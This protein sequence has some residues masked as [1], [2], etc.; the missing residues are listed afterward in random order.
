[1][2]NFFTQTNVRRSLSV[3]LFIGTSFFS[4]GQLSG[5]YT[6]P[7][8]Y[9]SINAFITDLN[10]VGVGP[11]G[12]T[13][14]VPAGYTETAPAGGFVIT[15]TGNATDQITI[16]GAGLPQPV[17]TAS[18]A[19]TVGALNDGIFKL[20]GSDYVTIAN[21]ELRENA[22]N[23]TTASATNNMTEW[24]VA[25]L[26]AS[27]TDGAKNNTIIGNT[28]SLNRT[29]TNSFGIYSNVRHNATAVTTAADI[30]APSG[31]NS[32]NLVYG[33]VISNVN[34][35][36]A[37]IGS[38]VP[39]NMDNG[40]DIGGSSVTSGNTITNWGGAGAASGYISNS[41]ISYCIFMNHQIGSNISYN[42]LTSATV[43]GTSVTFRGIVQDFT[44]AA[45]TGT[46][47]NNITNNQITMSSG[48]T[49][50]T[51]QHIF[52]SIFAATSGATLNINSNLLLNSSMSG[53]ASSSTM[54]GIIN[55]GAYGTVNINNNVLRG[56]TSTATTGGMTGISNT[57]AVVN[58]INM[59]NNALG[60]ASGNAITH[61]VAT[62]GAYTGISNTGGASTCALSIT[63][64]NFQGFVQSVNGTN[65]HTYITNSATT[66]SQ[67]IN[68]NT[69]TNLVAST[70][71]N[72][73]FI[74]NSVA[75]AATGIQNVNSN[76]ISGTFSKPGAGGTITL[77][78]TNASSAAG[79]IVSNSNNN[80]SNIT[81]TGAATIAGWVN[82]DGGSPQKTIANNT[83][84]N[85]TG[86]TSAITVIQQ[87][88]G[89]NGSNITN[90]TI[91]NISGQGA[92]TAINF[93]ASNSGAAQVISGNT[94]S[95]I[96]S[97]G[98]GGAVLGITTGSS[99]VTSLSI[100]GNNVNTLSS[101]AAS[102]VT[103]LA[104]SGGPQVNTFKNKF[105]AL[106]T[107]NAGGTVIGVL[108]S[109]GTATNTHNNLISEL[110]A[111]NASGND[112]IRGI[113]LTATTATTN[114]LVAYNTIYLNATSVGANFGTTGIFHNGSA[115][116]TT[117]RLDLRNNVIINESTPNGTGSTVAF[118]RFT[119][120]STNLA[121]TSN[122]NM[123]YAGTPAANR[124][125]YTD[126]TTP[127]QTLL[128]YQ[129]SVLPV[130][131]DANSM[132]G[133]AAFT[134]LGYGSAGNF[135]ISLT[136]SSND[137]LRPV[138]GITTQVESGASNITVPSITDDYTSAARQGNA[139]YTGT[140]TNPDMGAYEFEG[141]SP[142]PVIT[143]NSVTPPSTTQCTA[144]ARLISV[145]ITTTAG[146]ITSANIGYTMNGVAQANIPMTNTSGNIWEGT[147]PA[148]TPGNAVIAWGVSATNSLG[149]NGSYTGTSY[150]DEPLFGATATATA[151]ATTVCAN[152]PSTLTAS[153]S[154]VGSSVSGS[155]TG[156]S[157]AS[158]IS[159][160]YH[161]YGGVK[162]QYIFR[163]SELTA[164]G[165]TAGNFS[166]LSLNVTAVGTATR[167]NFT[168]DMGHTAQN[169]AVTNTAITAGL[170]Q[171]YSNAAQPVVLGAN[172][173]NF[174]TPF[175]WDGVSNIVIS[176]NWSNVNTGGTSAT[177]T[178]DP[179]LSFV[180]SLA[181]FADNAT[182][183]CLYT[184]VS[185]G[186]ACMGTNSNSTSSTRP[187]MTFTGQ[188]AP[189]ITSVQ[190]MDGA[191]PVGTG[192]PV[193]VNPSVT[194]TYTANITAAGCVYSPAPTVTVNVNPLPSTPTAA[195]S[196]QCGTQV[197]TASVTS[198]S[199]LPTPTFNW[200]DAPTAGT[201]LQNSTSTTYTS[202]VA[203]TTTFYVSELNTATGC[204]SARVAVTVT[205]AAADGIAAST[206]ATTIC[207]GSSF[208][209]S[210]VNTNPTPNQNYT[211]TWSS[212]ANSGANPSVNG[213]NVT[214]TP[215]EPGTYTYDVT[216][217]DG[218]CNAF[219]QVTVTVDPFAAT[220]AP[221]N[222]S[223]NG[224]ADGSFTLVS[225]SCGTIPYTYS[226]DG[227][228]F[229]AIPT[230][231]PAGTY[232]IIVMDDNGYVTPD[233]VITI[234][235]PSTTITNPSVTN[236]TVCQNDPSATVT[237]SAFTSVP[238]PGTL[239]ASFGTNLV[240]DGQ[241][242]AVYNVTVPALPANAT[243]TGTT[244]LLQNVNAING[245]WRS[246][247][248]VALSGASTLGATQISTLGSGGLITPDPS[249]TIPNLPLA[250]GTVTLS[251]TETYNDGGATVDAT[252]GEVSIIIN[253][254]TPT[255]ATVSW[256]DA[257]TGG[258][259]LG[260]GSPFETV[261][262]SVLPNTAT[263]GTYTVYAQGQNGAC[264]S[265]GRT[266][267]TI[268][269]K[270]KT[271]NTI[272]Q[273]ACNSYTLNSQTYTTS[274]TYTQTLVNAA[275]CD[276]IIT[277]NLT[278]NYSTTSTTNVTECDTYTWTNGIT[279]TTSGVYTQ[280]L[281][282]AAGCDSIATLNLTINYSNTGTDVI[283]ACE[284]YTW[285][286]GNTYTSS[287]N[288][289]TFL[290]TNAAGCDSLVTLNLTINYSNTGTD[291]ITACDSYTWIDGNTYTSNNNTATFLLTNAA[292][293]DSL[294]TLDLTI[295]SSNTGTD[296]VTACDSY[297]WIDGNTYTSSNNT[298]T[299]VLTNAAGCDS[300]VT[301]NLTI[302][303]S[304]AGTDVITA[305]DS[306][307]WIDGNTYTSS[308]NTATYVLTN[309]VG[310][311]SLVTLDLTIN[312]ST[313]GTDVINSCVPITWI[314][315]NTYASNNNTATF[316]LT[317]AAGCDSIV[318]LNLTI[319]PIPVATAT[320]NGD[321]SITAS[322]GNS[323]EWIDCA[324]GLTIAGESSQTYVATV[325]GSYQVVVFNASGCSDT[326]TCVVI[327]YIG[328]R[329]ISSEMIS[330]YPNPTS[331]NVTISMSAATA[332]V[333]ILDG[334]GKLIRS[335]QIE[336]GKPLDL[337]DLGMG[338]YLFRIT[339][340]TNTTIHRV[341][342]N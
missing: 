47:T 85:W 97:T 304:S 90:N 283:T 318:T 25:L 44:V 124:L 234:T 10:L 299:Y 167:N 128:G 242:P 72:I 113:S 58:T 146:T 81:V 244:L 143:L 332:S 9:P 205:V 266:A 329:E 308:N 218:L 33:N 303:Y 327:D 260:T 256:W 147:I 56:W 82:T 129:T 281:T 297:T 130:G 270:A 342:K 62:N 92:I 133:E 37:F 246:E 207:I 96:N 69:F 211:Y 75:L 321:A 192:N 313:T 20:I 101:T 116:A 60:N 339:T 135:F 217:V 34:L 102:A 77:Y 275:G 250:G 114:H 134:A 178:T 66:L 235:E 221:V 45:P 127:Q 181:I 323:Y 310:C 263:P 253:Y 194:T 204:E 334:N 177:V 166:S 202:N 71:G 251:L 156:T 314:D 222:A 64:N 138:A 197:P 262:T 14:S 322:A 4:F 94:I 54:V 53:A 326:S 216:G 293:C 292:G 132:T 337:S 26:Y 274:G 140:G 237:A 109:G 184:A 78:T 185:S 7:A 86:G 241:A 228:A 225:S 98:T 19:L 301:L 231:L 151:S 171:V 61:S 40:N 230:D 227:G 30:T 175:N 118:R 65:S 50:G 103:G 265:P 43:T 158:A 232:T 240:S 162:T 38:S 195:N 131:H 278:I 18:A 67:N 282:N 312:Y 239:T 155:G 41:G 142:A 280:T 198:T 193:T 74:S 338:V 247:I 80:F 169:A 107:S 267:A 210:V 316:V 106:S 200:Y 238:I 161:F 209:L 335:T 279:Y 95:G 176:F 271:Y 137:F 36:I 272:N 255:P 150:S 261:G 16:T 252:F 336:N 186:Q 296:V 302:K 70:T 273:T 305:C 257:P 157:S 93:G 42:T 121:S 149:L 229:G 188:K 73:T 28:I 288:T 306:Y 125:I 55:T 187:T 174:S 17:I 99:T 22:A 268:V 320:D 264:P 6:I 325:N 39:A 12:V 269:V 68:G 51:F 164:M 52:T 160:L 233:Q 330:I 258:T 213:A 309:A 83:F 87:N 201:L 214:I 108:I 57:G 223:C 220:I 196:A 46:F 163:A 245:S 31:S 277:L 120:N 276:S 212:V 21:L 298:A 219:A 284:S 154:N 126:G 110:T 203:S 259:Q 249:L 254:T 331:D 285:I 317:N 180:S 287:N 340:E 295:N 27:Q 79:S 2:R 199:G 311:D 11:G 123:L 333:E 224:I 111:P 100:S 122:R 206:S 183:S 136:G 226:V 172:T 141:I 341:V 29:Y 35:G 290:L 307:T 112:V 152:N 84:S 191:T 88:W 294:V 179:A 59:S 49:S 3:I 15:A 208:N 24:G 48:F 324:T 236:A 104:I 148:S 289:A 315:G 139:G 215:S 170:T 105:Y 159:P 76:S 173:Y 89:G 91:T 23:T 190:W 328:I 291:V 153:L 286:D 248:R 182:A 243:I 300:T 32:N 1:M 63:N 165:F 5:T 319:D 117:A 168:I 145:T 119:A 115:T 8:N 189:A 13:L 144:S